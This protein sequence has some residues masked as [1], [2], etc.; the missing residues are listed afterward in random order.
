MPRSLRAICFL[1]TLFCL[2]GCANKD[3]GTITYEQAVLRYGPPDKEQR[4]SGKKVAVWNRGTTTERTKFA[5]NEVYET[6]VRQMV[7][8]FDERDVLRGARY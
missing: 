7:L 4:V 1:L 2:V 8:T 5:G 3:I 6:S